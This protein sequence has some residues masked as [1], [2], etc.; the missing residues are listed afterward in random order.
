MLDKIYLYTIIKNID[1]IVVQ[2]DVRKQLKGQSD[3]PETLATL[4]NQYYP[5]TL[6]TLGNQDY[7]ETLATLGNQ[8]YPETLAT[9]GNQDY[10]ETLA[11]LGNQDYTETLATQHNTRRQTQHTKLKKYEQHRPTKNPEVNPWP[12]DHMNSILALYITRTGHT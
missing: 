11:T 1:F 4:G 6:A 2:I 5:E 8:D 10:P 9:L 3:Y 7:P 12:R